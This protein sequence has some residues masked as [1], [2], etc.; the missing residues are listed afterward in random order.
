VGQHL[1]VEDTMSKSYETD[2]TRTYTVAFPALTMSAMSLVLK[3]A[4]Q[5]ARANDKAAGREYTGEQYPWTAQGAVER[6]ED[7]LRAALEQ[8][9]RDE[10]FDMGYRDR[11]RIL[12]G[13][14]ACV[15]LAHTPDML[16]ESYHLGETAAIKADRQRKAQDL[17]DLRREATDAVVNQD[18]L[19]CERLASDKR[20][21]PDLRSTLYRVARG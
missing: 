9:D 11:E 1:H 17:R 15:D 5:Q 10:W 8:R 16:V 12:R 2:A 7:V 13:E 19:A 6:V 4:M 14:E 20:L 21:S 3:M 18:R